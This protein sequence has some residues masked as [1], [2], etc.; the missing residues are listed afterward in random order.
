MLFR[1]SSG[2]ILH[3][4]KCFHNFDWLLLAGQLLNVGVVHTHEDVM[5]LSMV[6]VLCA[7][8]PSERE[9]YLLITNGELAL[10][11]LVRLGVL[12]ELPDGVVV[13][14]LLCE[15]HVTLRVLVAWVD[16]GIIRKRSKNLIERFVHLSCIALEEASA[17]TNE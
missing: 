2:P 16:L 14:N 13:Q 3:R 6:S 12:I 11:L 4:A 15:A 5:L 7:Q 8:F 10:G 1:S 17:T 9:N